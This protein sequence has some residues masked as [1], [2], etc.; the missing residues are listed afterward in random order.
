MFFSEFVICLYTFL[1]CF[2][3]ILVVVFRIKFGSS[4]VGKGFTTFGTDSFA[5]F[6]G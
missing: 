6:Y 1:I 3:M 2:D 5:S 4:T